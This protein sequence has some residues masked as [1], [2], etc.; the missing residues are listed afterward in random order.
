MAAHDHAGGTDRQTAAQQ[1]PAHKGPGKER[2]ILGSDSC[3]AAVN[4]QRDLEA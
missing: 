3:A 2:P 1:L 4:V